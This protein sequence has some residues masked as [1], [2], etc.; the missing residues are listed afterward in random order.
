MAKNMLSV[1]AQDIAAAAQRFRALG[2]RDI[3]EG[4]P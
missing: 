4:V 3:D 2:S 1:H